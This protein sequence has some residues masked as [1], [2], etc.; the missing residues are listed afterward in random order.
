MSLEKLKEVL[1][2]DNQAC[3]RPM[4]AGAL[5]EKDLENIQFPMLASYKVDGYRCVFWRGKAYTRAGK[6]H[7]NRKVQ[8]LAKFV[9]FPLDGELIV[10]GLPFNQAG[11][12]LRR[13]D[14]DG[15]FELLVFDY[16]QEELPAQDRFQVLKVVQSRWPDNIKLLGQTWLENVDQLKGF[17]N[18]ALELGFEGVVLRKPGAK[19]KHGRGTLKDQIM[20]KLKRFRSAEAKV[21]GVEPRMYN[22]NQA[23][24]TPL[25]YTE[26][27]TAKDGLIPT[28]VLGKF[29]VI[30][31]NGPFKGVEFS[32]GNFDGLSDEDKISLLANPPIGEVVTYKYF[33][34]AI[35]DKPRHP[36]FLNFRPGWD[37]GKE[38]E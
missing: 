32:I 30:G 19:Y 9:D 12:L 23:E 11:G 31:V 28:N 5:G 25:G 13:A 10:P 8:E 14:Y 22:S 21:L 36:V 35:L 33:P 38:G 7:P 17:E 4:L 24:T 15:P 16:L 20:L 27:S 26:R 18:Q 2:G 6:L 3:P 1:E 34:Q 37:L 29:H